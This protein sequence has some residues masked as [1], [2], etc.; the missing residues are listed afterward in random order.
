MKNHKGASSAADHINSIAAI[1]HDYLDRGIMPNTHGQSGSPNNSM[2]TG[3]HCPFCM[4]TGFKGT[5]ACP[6]CDG[7]GRV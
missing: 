4:G 5:L 1:V 3:H 6:H 7:R 2:T